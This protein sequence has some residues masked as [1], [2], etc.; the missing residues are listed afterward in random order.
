MGASLS[1][2]VAAVLLLERSGDFPFQDLL[3]VSLSDWAFLIPILILFAWRR[4]D[5]HLLGFRRFEAQ[6]LALVEPSSP[7]SLVIKP[8]LSPGPSHE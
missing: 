3:A 8:T 4:W 7:Y 6:A 2:L 5:W 1:V